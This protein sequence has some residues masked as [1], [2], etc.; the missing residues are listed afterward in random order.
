MGHIEIKGENEAINA[1]GKTFADNGYS[2]QTLMTELCASP[3]FTL[4]DEPK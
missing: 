1:L 2:L 3:A 4:V